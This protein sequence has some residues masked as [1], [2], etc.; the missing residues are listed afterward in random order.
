MRTG[1][2][3]VQIDDVEVPGWQSVTIPAKSIEQGE[4]REGNES[5]YKKDLWGQTS[6]DDL[7]MVRVMR[8]TGMYEWTEAVRMG[9][10]EVG[11]KDV[12]VV[13]LNEDDRP[14]ISWEFTDVWPKEYQP[15]ELDASADDDVATESLTCS[16]QDM[17]VDLHLAEGGD[18]HESGVSQELF[19]A[20]T[21]DSDGELTLAGLRGA[22]EEWEE[23]EQVGG[24]D[25]TLGD[26]RALVGWWEDKR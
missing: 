12:A 19:D 18:Q 5:E 13:L 16:F 14:Q 25:A 24:V 10:T 15:P 11:Q 9:Q 8:D 6:V 4:Y 23:D 1:R 20:V 17:S 21:A 26:I 2:F 7:E 22:V 3:K